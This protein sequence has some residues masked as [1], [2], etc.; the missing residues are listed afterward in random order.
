MV[1]AVTGALW[2]S[3]FSPS[4]L[5]HMAFVIIVRNSSDMQHE[6]RCTR[7]KELRVGRLNTDNQR[8]S[9]DSFFRTEEEK[10]CLKATRSSMLATGR[11]RSTIPSS[12][13]QASHRLHRK[14]YL[15]ARENVIRHTKTM[16][17]HMFLS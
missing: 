13:S 17:P 7:V 5:N 4:D 16:G 8:W 3:F 14:K 15:A 9:L 2:P 12:S 11:M 6:M 10:S 1:M